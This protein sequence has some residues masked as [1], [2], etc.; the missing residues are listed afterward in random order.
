MIS[1]PEREQ[2]LRDINR[3][4][5]EILSE[6]AAIEEKWQGRRPLD[7]SN[8]LAA[9]DEELAG[10]RR[11]RQLLQ[12]PELTPEMAK[13]AVD[14]MW[15]MVFLIEIQLAQLPKLAGRISDLES[16]W[17]EWIRDDTQ[18]RTR[19]QSVQNAYGVVF[20]IVLAVDIV[21]RFVVR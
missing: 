16:H 3:R 9:L 10:L 4:L 6:R 14:R 5:R 11:E 7:V 12:L 21:T 8:D 13:E 20:L 17:A 18:A 15:D 2:R 19:R 1:E